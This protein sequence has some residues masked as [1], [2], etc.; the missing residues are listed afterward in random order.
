LKTLV[1]GLGNPILSDDGIGVRVAQEVRHCLS[2]GVDVMVSEVSVG[3]LDLMEAM[4]GYER[5]ILIDAIQL[6]TDHPGKIHRMSLSDIRDISPTQH[7]TSP[8]DTSLIT[9]LDM[10]QNIGLEIPT[11]ITIFAIEVQNILEFGEELT[12]H[13]AA[14]L[15]EVIEMVMC[16]LSRDEPS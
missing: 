3:G 14:A 1:L 5:V 7:S 8:H 11:E 4:I 13:V 9:A 2:E 10:A 15:P 6:E 16:E 12:P